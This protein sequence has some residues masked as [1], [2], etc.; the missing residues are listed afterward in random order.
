MGH[1]FVPEWPP[2]PRVIHQERGHGH[3]QGNG[4]LFTL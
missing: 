2:H 1:C 4:D 3:F